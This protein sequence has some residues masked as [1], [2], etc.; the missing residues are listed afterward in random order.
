L[1]KLCL[2]TWRRNREDPNV[3]REVES[4][5]VHPQRPSQPAA[6]EVEELTVPR[7]EMQPGLDDGPHVVDPEPLTR[8][9]QPVAIKDGQ[10]ADV[11]PPAEIVRPQHAQVQRGQSV[12]RAPPRFTSSVG[13]DSAPA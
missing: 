9:E 1:Q 4:R 5:G 12:H 7:H 2:V 13:R 8:V 11:L 10:A 6:R 3:I